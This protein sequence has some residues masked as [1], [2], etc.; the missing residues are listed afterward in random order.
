MQALLCV[1]FA[2]GVVL[3]LFGRGG[4]QTAAA[5]AVVGIS[6]FAVAIYAMRLR[7]Q[8]R[9]LRR[10]E[11]SLPIIII[12]GIGAAWA[13]TGNES[14]PIWAVLPVLAIGSAGKVPMREYRFLVPYTF[15]V[16][17]AATVLIGVSSPGG[18][19]WPLTLA[20][21][22]ITAGACVAAVM[23]ARQLDVWNREARVMTETDELTGVANRR[24]FFAEIE[25]VAKRPGTAFAILMMDLDDFK[26][27][28]DTRGHLYG[29]ETLAVAADIAQDCLRAGDTL[30]RYGGEE[31]AAL[32]HSADSSAAMT[33]AER[34]RA[35]IAG[36]TPTSVSIGIATSEESESP[37]AVL[38]LAD[39]QLL[40]AKR[41]GKNVVHIGMG[42]TDAA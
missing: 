10:A 1:L 29:D 12:T 7:V 27:L 23:T 25:A 16:V 4:A 2:A 30:A 32:L 17:V 20:I 3:A 33:V 13:T 26:E 39:Q 21:W 40:L 14:S 19:E 5:I 38:Q 31:F 37:E 36:E 22:S 35:R 15:L 42:M 34:I 24:K 6:Q 18:F 11:Q 28:N 9:P 8:G 41:S